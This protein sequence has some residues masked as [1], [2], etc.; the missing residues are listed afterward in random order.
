MATEETQDVEQTDQ[1]SAG[2]QGGSGKEYEKNDAGQLKEMPEVTEE[3]KQKAAEMAKAYDE[4]IKTTTLPGSDGTVVGTAV[5]EWVDDKDKGNVETSAEEGKVEYRNSE[6]FK[7][8]QE[9]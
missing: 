1:E 2:D 7:K 5:S 9:S 3:H 4:S 8:I 6:E